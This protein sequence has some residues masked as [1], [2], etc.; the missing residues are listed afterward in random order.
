MRYQRISIINRRISTWRDSAI[1]FDHFLMPLFNLLLLQGP[2]YAWSI[3]ELCRLKKLLW[4]INIGIYR[5]L[6]LF[7]AKSS[8]VQEKT[9]L[10]QRHKKIIKGQ[11]NWFF[12]YKN[13]KGIKEYIGKPMLTKNLPCLWRYTNGAWISCM[14][15][16]SIW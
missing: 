8:A 3:I 10:Y 16:Y 5:F 4:G 6:I 7:L 9:N 14:R 11:Q 1:I 13:F 12:D 15:Y 2:L